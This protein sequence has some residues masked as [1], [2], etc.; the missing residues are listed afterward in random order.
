MLDASTPTPEARL[1]AYEQIV[2]A[3]VRL[4]PEAAA[5]IHDHVATDAPWAPI[6]EEDVFAVQVEI[7]QRQIMEAA[8]A[9]GAG[10]A[11]R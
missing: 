4:A 1:E 7:A 3:F 5:Q 10:S 8:L 9:A 11:V 2:A 6:E